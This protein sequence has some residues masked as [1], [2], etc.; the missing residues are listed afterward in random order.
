VK[1]YVEI[2][3][4]LR[5]NAVLVRRSVAEGAAGGRVL[6]VPRLGV[7]PDEPNLPYIP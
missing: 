4:V 2:R 3:I 5:R 6:P 7:E 1:K